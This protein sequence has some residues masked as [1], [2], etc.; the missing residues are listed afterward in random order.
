MT[1]SDTQTSILRQAA[2]HP[3]GLAV[4]STHLPPGPRAAIAPALLNAGLVERAEPSDSNA[5]W[6]LDGEVIGLTI[7]GAGR[8][9]LGGVADELPP[10]PPVQNPAAG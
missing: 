5:G 4:P 8:K 10:A 1:L 3:D 2:Q 9:A 7:T 6:K